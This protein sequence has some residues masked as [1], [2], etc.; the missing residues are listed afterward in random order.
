MSQYSTD[1]LNDRFLGCLLLAGL[2]LSIFSLDHEYVGGWIGSVLQFGIFLVG[3]LFTR[4]YPDRVRKKYSLKPVTGG[5]DP[6][7]GNSEN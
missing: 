1:R 7:Q 6:N 5:I 4:C 3:V 2:G